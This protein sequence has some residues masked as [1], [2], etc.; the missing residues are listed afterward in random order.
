VLPGEEAGQPPEWLAPLVSERLRVVGG[1]E[2]RQQSVANGLKRLGECRLVL[3]HDA[4]RR[5]STPSSS[6]ECSRSQTWAACAVPGLPLADTVKETDTPVSWCARSRANGWSRCRRRRPSRPMLE[7]A[8]QRA[9]NDV[10]LGMV[11]DDAALCERLGYPVRVVPGS[12]RT[13][14]SRP[15]GL[16]ARR[17]ARRAGERALVMPF[18]TTAQV[19]KAIP[20]AVLHWSGTV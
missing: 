12:T 15:R 2:A 8:H 20:E 19:L 4:A 18:G 6:I 7:T 14:R 13:S 16:H 1:G 10:T 5:S 9:R 11:T 3:V 17:G